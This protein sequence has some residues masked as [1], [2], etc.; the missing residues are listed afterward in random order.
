VP[1]LIVESDWSATNPPS[2]PTIS[3]NTS[4]QNFE[5]AIL[6]NAVER[7]GNYIFELDTPPR[8]FRTRV[9]SYTLGA[10]K[11]FI[12]SVVVETSKGLI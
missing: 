2:M 1:F 5:I 3:Q 7:S 6:F 10:Y 9:V 11:V 4:C 8:A 12:E